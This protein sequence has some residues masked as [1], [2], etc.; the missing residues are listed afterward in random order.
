MADKWLVG[1]LAQAKRAGVAD[2]RSGPGAQAKSIRG[3]RN[4]GPEPVAARIAAY[5]VTRSTEDGVV[6]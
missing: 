1:G 5:T 3:S 4:V 2:A 6:Q